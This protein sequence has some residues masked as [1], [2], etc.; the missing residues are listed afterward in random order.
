MTQISLRKPRGRHK[1][2]ARKEPMKLRLKLVKP[3]IQKLLACSLIPLMATVN[4]PLAAYAASQGPTPPEVPQYAQ[5][6]KSRRVATTASQSVKLAALPA[7]PSDIELTAARVFEEP[8][9][10]MSGSSVEGE[11]DELAKA[12][13]SFKVKND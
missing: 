3:I 5:N 12:I 8:L 9:I 11:N 7:H 13:A 2:R 10:P 1:Q 6:P 4:M